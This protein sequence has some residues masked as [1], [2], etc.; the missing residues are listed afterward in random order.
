M[1][2]KFIGANGGKQTTSDSLAA[3]SKIFLNEIDVRSESLKA[4]TMRI[5]DDLE[6]FRLPG[7]DEQLRVRTQTQLNLISLVMKIAHE[8]RGIEELTIATYTFN[9]EAFKILTDM[10]K[11]GSIGKLNL[12][13]ASSY[14]F[15]EPE[16]SEYLKRTCLNLSKK[17]QLSLFF[18]WAH[19][20]ITLAKCGSHFYQFEGSMNYSMNNMAEQLLIC[21]SRTVYEYDYDFIMNVCRNTKNKALEIIC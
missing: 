4:P 13:I 2:W 1:A 21:D 14:N 3:K 18:A 15:R 9:K 12:L 8:R 11:G 17:Y 20:K 5:L 6:T 16:Y 19:F 10:L 7:K